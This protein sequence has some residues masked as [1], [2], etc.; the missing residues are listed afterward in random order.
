[1]KTIPFIL[2]FTIICFSAICKET[3]YHGS[4]PAHPD[5]RDFLGISLSDSLD[6][7]RWNVVM[8]EDRYQLNCQY[9][10]SK[11]NTNGFIN[12][13]KVAFSGPLSKQGYYY[14]LQKG[15][16]TFYVKEINSN[17]LHLLDKNKAM[18]IGNGGY[19]YALNI[20]KPIKTGHLNLQVKQAPPEYYMAFQGRTPCQ[21]LA[22]L[23]AQNKGP[24]CIK[25]KWYIILYIDSVTKKPTYYLKGGMGYRKETMA[26]GNWEITQGKDGRVIYKL[27][28]E[29]KV[30]AVY[31]VKADDNILFFTDSEGN[32][33]VGNEDFSYTLNRTKDMEPL[34]RK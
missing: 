11:A 20:D 7:I 22:K 33:L 26:K 13:K 16:K 1:M 6:F 31:L 14:H 5:V 15:N 25:M 3:I 8:G 32:L 21:P 24:E 12:E 28:P 29:K 10:L 2:A 18:L 4:T 23:L 34:A 30:N 9:G 17:L 27:D 19:S